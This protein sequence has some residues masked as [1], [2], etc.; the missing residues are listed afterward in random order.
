MTEETMLAPLRDITTEQSKAIAQ[1]TQV[2]AGLS[3][4]FQQMDA[5]I[6]ALES[7]KM[8]ATILH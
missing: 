3:A 8:Q 2:S 4:L 6:R 5:R 1:L 7:D